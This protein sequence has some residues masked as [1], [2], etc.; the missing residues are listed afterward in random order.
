MT[1]DRPYDNPADPEPTGS[2]PDAAGSSGGSGGRPAGDS[3]PGWDA[4][5]TSASDDAGATPGDR[6]LSQLQSMIDT[7]ATQAKPVARQIGLKAAELTALAADRAVPAAHKAGDVAA[8]ASGKLA[9]RSREFAEAMRRELGISGEGQPATADP[10]D[11]GAGGSS[12]ASDVGST[13]TAVMDR[14]V[15]EVVDEVNRGEGQP[16]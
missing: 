5:S 15:D 9:T 4:G 12:A 13:A 3:I 2:T 14:P 16:G 10:D 1:D 7:I 8:D 6:M 11:A